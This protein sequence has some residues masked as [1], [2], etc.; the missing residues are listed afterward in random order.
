MTGILAKIRPDFQITN[1]AW[2]PA[3]EPAS[4]NKG[5]AD[6]PTFTSRTQARVAG[7]KAK[8]KPVTLQQVFVAGLRQRCQIG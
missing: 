3:G 2:L 8:I 5:L 1:A 7:G 4:E 6:L